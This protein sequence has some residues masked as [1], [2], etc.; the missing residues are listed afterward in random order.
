M[1]IVTAVCF[2]QFPHLPPILGMMTGLSYLLFYGYYIRMTSEPSWI[3]S[4]R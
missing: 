1:T 4:S 2:E 3:T